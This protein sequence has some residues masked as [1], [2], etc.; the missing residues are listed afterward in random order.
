MRCR[1]TAAVPRCAPGVD[2]DAKRGRAGVLERALAPAQAQRQRAVG[3]ARCSVQDQHAVPGSPQPL[4]Q[5]AQAR[6]VPRVGLEADG[7]HAAARRWAEGLLEDRQHA[8][9]RVLVRLE[10]LPYLRRAGPILIEPRACWRRAG[11]SEAS[12]RPQRGAVCGESRAVTCTPMFDPTS[13]NRCSHLYPEIRSCTAR[14]SDI[15]AVVW[16][17]SIQLRAVLVYVH[18]QQKERPSC[19]SDEHAGAMYMTMTTVRPG[20][21]FQREGPG[22]EPGNSLGCPDGSALGR[23]LRGES[24][25]SPYH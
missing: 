8:G 19:A 17:P 21:F 22:S 18:K 10:Q 7:A 14:S 16:L 24:V 25:S 1:E 2:A 15:I 9:T 5:L 4:L 6:R 3:G 12:E 11:D 23:C 13:R 20:L